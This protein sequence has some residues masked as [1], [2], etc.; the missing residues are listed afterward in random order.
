[1]HE[2]IDRFFTEHVPKF[3]RSLQHLQDQVSPE[4][5]PSSDELTRQLTDRINES[6]AECARLES[7]LS[8]AEP[9]LRAVQTAYR[10]AIW[11]WFG[12][13]WFMRRALEKPRGYPGDFEM[14]SAIYDAAPKSRGLGGYLDRYFLATTLARAVRGRMRAV[15]QFLLE[16][17]SRRTGDLTVLNVACGPCREYMEHFVPQHEGR[18][19]LVCIDNDPMALDFV[20]SYVVPLISDTIHCEFVRYNA[21]R[22]SSTRRNLANF[23]RADIIYSVGL[24]DYLSDNVLVPILRGWGESLRE[25]G[26]VYVAF[27]DAQ[28]YETPEYQWLVDWFFLQR[29]EPECRQLFAGAGYDMEH[30]ELD[31][32]VTGVILD[33]VGRSLA[34]QIV[35]V[36]SADELPRPPRVITTPDSQEEPTSNTW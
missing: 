31:R 7:Q 23:G 15:R 24:C 29:T 22:M 27:K 14:L 9:L 34:R 16:E 2:S 3:T 8:D 11:P 13:S 1:M 18:I 20:Q 4:E 30:L 32:D 6:L 36:D 25:D 17:L 21:L 10:E 12:Q 5:E 19:R 35:R 33:Y 28:R 26:L